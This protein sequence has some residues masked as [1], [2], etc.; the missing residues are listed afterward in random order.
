MAAFA[1][2]I[3]G[4]VQHDLCVGMMKAKQLEPSIDR[5]DQIYRQRGI[6]GGNIISFKENSYVAEQTKY[7]KLV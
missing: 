4:S 1:L 6:S 2:Q 5:A 3:S 7:A